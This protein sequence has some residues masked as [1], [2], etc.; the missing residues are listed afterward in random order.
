MV[1]DEPSLP[2]DGTEGFSGSDT[3]AER[4]RSDAT[5]GTAG[6]RQRA[7]LDYLTGVSW[8]GATWSEV[9]TALSLHHGQASASLSALHQAD[10]IARLSQRRGRSQ[11]YVM[12]E[13]VGERATAPFRPNSSRVDHRHQAWDE[14][15]IAG[16]DDGRFGTVT[17][18]PY[19]E[20]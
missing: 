1:S 19:P 3:S 6:R 16:H 2:Y 5:D 17:R 9:A 8:Y 7:V 15:Y 13:Y 4:A 12:P 18:N 11:I 10:R 14:G 20:E